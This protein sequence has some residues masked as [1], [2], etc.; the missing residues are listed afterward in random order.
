M[1]SF[2]EY[3]VPLLRRTPRWR[4]LSAQRSWSPAGTVV[5]NGQ[6]PPLDLEQLEDRLAPASAS[7]LNL[8]PSPVAFDSATGLLAI[9][10]PAPGDAI[11][12]SLAGSDLE[13][14]LDGQGYSSNP[15]SAAFD[16]ALQGASAANL[17]FLQLSGPGQGS[18]L[19]TDFHAAHNLTVCTDGAVR[20]AGQ[21]DSTATLDVQGQTLEVAGAVHGLDLALTSTGLLTIDGGGR[22]DASGG[23]GGQILVN[24]AN[25]LNEGTIAA[26]GSLGAGGLVQID[27][28]SA[29]LDTASALT[30]VNGQGGPGGQVTISG[31]PDGHLFSSGSQQATGSVGGTI[32]LLGRD[33]VLAGAHADASGESGGGVI[34]VGGGRHGDDASLPNAQTV[35]V[36]ASTT[37]EASAATTGNGGQVIVWADDTN[38]FAG[39]VTARGG[40]DGGDGGFVEV[41]AGG[42]LTYS[43]TVDAGAATGQ[44]GTLLLD[45]QNLVISNAPPAGVAPQFPLID[46][47]PTAGGKFGDTVQ[48]LGNGNVVVTNPNDD[49]GGSNAGAVYLFDGQTGSLLGALVGSHSGDQVGL[50][51]SLTALADGNYVVVSPFW[52]N[53]SAG[54]AGAVTLVS[55]STG[56]TLTGGASTISPNN[57][58]VGSQT[59]DNVG[60]GR[61]SRPYGA[62]RWQLRRPQPQLGERQRDTGR[63][64]DA[65]QRQHRAGLERRQRHHLPQQQPRRQPNRRSGG[66]GCVGQFRLHSERDRAGRRQLRREEHQR[67]RG[68]GDAGQ[69][70]HRAD[71]DRRRQHH[72][73]Q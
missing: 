29:Y 57:S 59:N 71:L 41:S 34:H 12:I 55:G 5:R 15:T 36:L 7:S 30:S 49:L 44:A 68:S 8:I 26:D 54:A 16:P 3:P 4:S 47:H 33:I 22:V 2:W 28:S 67:R 56:L 32:D 42:E 63:S 72:L 73:R 66:L 60:G 43:G 10:S 13:I 20:L 27:V 61:R 1:S 17:A 6:R 70:Q 65:G 69:R 9:A 51:G 14:T 31:G 11:R 19:L 23:T 53:G 58:L 25:V 39:Q 62:G 21:V 37:L 18:L 52:A 45:P 40:T 46:P 38:A 50:G 48:V 64:G 24:A 35:Q